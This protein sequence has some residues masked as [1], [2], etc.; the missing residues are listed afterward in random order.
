MSYTIPPSPPTAR[1]W[2]IGTAL[3]G[4]AGLLSCAATDLILRVQAAGLPVPT[5]AGEQFASNLD[6]LLLGAK[7]WFLSQV[8]LA[9]L[10][11]IP[12]ARRLLFRA[13]PLA[14]CRAIAFVAGPLWLIFLFLGR[15]WPALLCAALWIGFHAL[16]G[17]FALP[18][19]GS[20]GG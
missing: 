2:I 8:A 7:I 4:A 5:D 16:L 3:G 9:A 14:L 13:V 1:R 6:A 10:L 12:P 17:W 15:S 20:S 11:L 19:D 18:I